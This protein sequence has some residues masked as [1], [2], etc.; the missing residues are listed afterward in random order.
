M[1]PLDPAAAASAVVEEVVG[2][3]SE[4]DLPPIEDKPPYPYFVVR[5]DVQLEVNFREK[6]IEGKSKIV[7]AVVAGCQVDELA[8]DARQTEID[9]EKIT[10]QVIKDL[11]PTGAPKKVSASYKDPYKLLDYPSYYNWNAEHHDLRKIRMRPL[12]HTRQS[13]VPAEN[14]ELVGCTPVDGALRVN[15]R[16]LKKVKEEPGAGVPKRPTLKIRVS[17]VNPSSAELDNDLIPGR[18]YRVTIPFKTKLVRDGIQFVGVDPGDL[19][20]PHAYTRHSIEPGTA[21]CIFPCIDDHGQLSTWS[22]AVKCPRTLGDALWQ[23]LATQQRSNGNTNGNRERGHVSH[24]SDREFSLTEEDKLLEMTVVCSGTLSDEIVD[25]HDE[26]KKIMSFDMDKR[27]SVQ[28]IGFAVGPFEHVDLFSDFRTEENDEKLGASALKIHGYCLPGR[29]AEVQNSCA[30]LAAAAD[31]FTLT[32]ARYPFENYKMCFLDDMVND[33]VA[34]QSLSFVST[35]LLFPEDIIDTEVDVTR[36]LVFSLASQWSGINLFPNTRRDLWVVIGIAYYMT[37][38]FLKKLCGNNDYRFRMKE[39]S[40]RLV[41]IDIKRPSL[42]ELGNLLHIGD[43]EMDFMILKAP[44]VLFILDKRLMKAPA[45]TNLTR[46]ISRIL[47]KAN[48]GEKQSEWIINTESFQRVCEKNARNKLE[49]FWHQWVYGSGCPRFDVYQRFNKKRLCVEMTIRQ[50]QDRTLTEAQVLKKTEFLRAVKEKFHGV[51]GEDTVGL[52]TG[53][54]TIRI[55]EADGTPYEHIVEIREDAAK[56]AKFEIPYNTKYKRLKRKRRAT[57]KLSAQSA[58][59]PDNNEETLLYCLGDV[60][61]GPDDLKKWE[62]SEWEADIEKAM[63][64]E[65]YEWIRMDADFEWACEMKTNLQSYM[66]VS[67]LQQDRDVVAQQDS[68]LYLKKVPAHP[69][70]STFLTR[71]LVDRRYFHGIRTMAAETLP[72][73]ATAKTSMVGMTHLLKAFTELFCYP[74]TQTPRPNDFSDKKQ[75]IVQSALPMAIARVRDSSGKCPEVA[76]RLLLNQVQYN[77]NANNPYS[78]HFYVAKL[79]DALATSLIPEKSGDQMDLDTNVE[80]HHFL[81][82]AL[83]EIDR[84]RRMDEWANS[85]QNIWTTTALECRRKLMK[86]G[87]IPKNALDF[88]QYLQDET[89]DLVRIKA[90]EALV[91]LGYMMEMPIFRLILSVISTDKSPFVRDK[92]LNIFCSGLAALAF[93]EQSGPNLSA[94]APISGDVLQIEHDQ[95]AQTRERRK[96]FDRKHDVDVALAAL[97]TEMEEQYSEHEQALQKAVWKALNS[98]VLGRAE[99]ITLLELCATMFDVADRWTITLNFPK[100]WRATRPVK[101]HPGRFMVNFKSYYK[102]ALPQVKPKEPEPEPEPQAQPPPPPQPQPVARPPEPKR[103]IVNMKSGSAKINKPLPSAPRPVSTAPRP[104][105]SP[106]VQ[107]PKPTSAPSPMADSIVASTIR[108]ETTPKP[109]T[110]KPSVIKTTVSKPSQ[111]T[112]LS[113]GKPAASKPP[114]AKSALPSG[115]SSTSNGRSTPQPGPSSDTL[116][117]KAHKRPRPDK[118]PGVDDA[119]PVLKKAKLNVRPDGTIPKRRRMVR[120][121]HPNLKAIMKKAGVVSQ[122]PPPRDP[123]LVKSR[124]PA[125]PL[126]VRASPAASPAPGPSDGSIMAKPARKPLPGGASSGA[127]ASPP[128]PPAT[129]LP[130]KPPPPQAS[131]PPADGQ[132]PP[133]RVKLVIKKPSSSA[134]PK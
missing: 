35:R 78:D 82:E 33:T 96:Q 60:L 10:I 86:A 133:K 65:S 24:K 15:L 130:P 29:A 38:L 55:H 110:P 21:S 102:T 85:Y 6:R 118:V 97:R 89:C 26:R 9:V 100:R 69:L 119:S 41:N 43:F 73:E 46:I 34:L 115:S 116:N 75:Y 16:D 48:I 63:D 11:Q 67:Q 74:D 37:D 27:V 68:M 123:S 117:S 3:D 72:Q 87:V 20:Y 111:T 98:A 93:G 14:R 126:S 58:A 23:P 66:Y 84:F 32:F 54:M 70:V 109:S 81:G 79:L 47:Y 62:F 127:A 12:T 45:Q 44:L 112:K 50:V 132:P 95:E 99:K 124:K 129:S 19:R 88:I 131:P 90:F 56:V 121:K 105:P 30:A 120:F 49:A 4:D 31:F 122:M 128:P 64:Q 101:P 107:S 113:V 52:F 8:I 17:N 77:N 92:L 1:N 40:D 106:A 42:H 39:M 13:D 36:Q 61:T 114:I 108:K 103:L 125:S 91:D 2:S 57:E 134:P 25:P 18:E 76:R 51:K 104:S 59:D 22:I 80:E 71:T 94:R 83:V 53:P 5:Q 28:K 7:I